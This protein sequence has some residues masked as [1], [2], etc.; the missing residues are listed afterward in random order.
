[1]QHVVT[2]VAGLIL[3][4]WLID[5]SSIIRAYQRR[6]RDR[7]REARDLSHITGARK[8]WKEPPND[9]PDGDH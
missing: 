3:L 5:Y 8:W 7:E 4:A 6:E 1:M 9:G 2:I